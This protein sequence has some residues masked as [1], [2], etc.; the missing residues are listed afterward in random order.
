MAV[1]QYYGWLEDS[2][3][4]RLLAGDRHRLLILLPVGLLAVTFLFPLMMIVYSSFFGPLYKTPSFGLNGYQFLASDYFGTLVKTVEFAVF[5]T[6]AT[7][8]M[9][10]PVAFYMRDATRRGRILA[11][12][13]LLAPLMV[14]IIIRNYGWVAILFEGGILNQWLLSTGV[15]DSP[16]QLVRNELGVYIGLVHVFLPFVALP[17]F[18]VLDSFDQ[19]IEEAAR[20]HGATRVQTFVHVTLPNLLPGIIAGSTIVFV[21]TLG[22][23]VTPIIMGGNLVITL[24]MSIRQFTSELLDW[25]FVTASATVLLTIALITIIGLNRIS[26]RTSGQSILEGRA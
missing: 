3:I 7:F 15:I 6:L 22:V 5:T 13:T 21:L 4:G 10:L 9:A 11:A 12:V 24:P 16:L 17:I 18:S 8:V 2:S 23:Y 20:V 26:E 1:D 14:N 25:R 19:S